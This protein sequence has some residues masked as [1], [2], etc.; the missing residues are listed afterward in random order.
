LLLRVELRP[1]G[2]RLV[3]VPLFHPL[4]LSCQQPL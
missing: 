2:F 1:Q 3:L 4:E